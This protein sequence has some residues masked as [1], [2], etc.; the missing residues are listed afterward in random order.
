MRPSQLLGGDLCRTEFMVHLF[1]TIQAV[2]IP[3]LLEKLL[4]RWC[5]LLPP[6]PPLLSAAVLTAGASLR[7]QSHKSDA[8]SALLLHDILK[9]SPCRPPSSP[10]AGCGLCW[11]FSVCCVGGVRT[12]CVS[13]RGEWPQETGSKKG[14]S[15]T[16]HH[17]EKKLR[18]R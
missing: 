1:G 6:P 8:Y 7:N 15:I 4:Q 11:L 13:P 3:V 5:P 16:R 10:P 2:Q 18:R 9:A 14:K 12:S 17:A